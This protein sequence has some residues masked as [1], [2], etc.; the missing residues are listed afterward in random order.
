MHL[1][2]NQL[3]A[4]LT[5][6]SPAFPT[7]GF[8]YSHGLEWAIEQ[9]TVS[10]APELRQWIEDLMD[11]G[12]CWNDAVLFANCWRYEAVE[13]NELALALAASSERHL[14]TAQ[15]GRAFEISASILLSRHP[16]KCSGDHGDWESG[17]A[18]PIAAGLACRR[19]RIGMSPSLLA[20]LNGFANALVSV[21]VRLVPLGQTQGL[22]VIR[23]LMPAIAATARRAETATLDDLGSIAIASDIAA[24]N[25]ETQ[26]SRVFR[27]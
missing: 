25:H 5:W 24:M 6:T 13:L 8:A 27:T 20:F 1:E 15:L 11:R 17:I 22:E 4:L 10:S 14:E 7:G 2:A 3:L 12:S 26:H 23:D 9:A 16:R 18:Y 21:A 19:L